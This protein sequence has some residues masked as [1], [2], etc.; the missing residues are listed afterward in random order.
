MVPLMEAAKDAVGLT[1]RDMGFTCSGSS[2][3]LAGQVKRIVEGRSSCF[4][5]DCTPGLDVGT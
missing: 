4:A 5:S 1:Q 2:D 3:F